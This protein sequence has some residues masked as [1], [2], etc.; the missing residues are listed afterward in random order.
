MSSRRIALIKMKCWE[1]RS[2][3]ERRFPG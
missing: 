1:K 2:G 3:R